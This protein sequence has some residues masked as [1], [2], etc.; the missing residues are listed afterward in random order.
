LPVIES[1]E[2][3]VIIDTRTDCEYEGTDIRSLRGGHLPNAIHI[4]YCNNFDPASFRMKSLSELRPLYKAIPS[5]AR[6]ITYCH[7]GA[8]AAYSYLVLRALGFK[9]VAVYHDGW[10][11]Y[12]SN[13]NLPVENETWYDFTKVN[14]L[15]NTVRELQEKLK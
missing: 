5:D 4:D 13:L 12:G 14:G 10:R 9:S 6:I 7:T 3:T 1:E 2:K 15:M 8:R 11:V